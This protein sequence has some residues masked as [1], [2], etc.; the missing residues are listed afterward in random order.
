MSPRLPP[1]D[2]RSDPDWAAIVQRLIERFPDLVP[3]RIA[4]I[5][6]EA[7]Y[8]VGLFAVSRD[9]ELEHGEQ[10]A[11]NLIEQQAKAQQR[12][13]RAMTRPAPRS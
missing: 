5:V 4:D 7:H 10:I 2:L 6:I 9:E 12:P 8:A 1:S 11:T 13:T 3:A